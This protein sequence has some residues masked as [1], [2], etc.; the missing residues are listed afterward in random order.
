[1][2]HSAAPG[3]RPRVLVIGLDSADAVLI[4]RW[5]AAGHL[6]VLT[7]L[8]REGVRGR[9]GT[10]AEVMHVSAWPTL[11]TGVDPG[12]HGMYHAYQIRAGEQEIHRAVAS[13]CGA[14]PYWKWLDDAGR[15]CIVLDAFMDYPLAGFRGIQIVDWGTWTW[16]TEAAREASPLVQD[17]R[18][19]VGDYPSPEHSDVVSVPDPVWFRDRLVAGAAAKARAARWLLREHAWD[20]A[21]VT[22]G[23]PHGA[24]HYLWH[25]HDPDFPW[26]RETRPAGLGDPLLEVYAAIDR[27]IGEILEETDDRT[28]VL[29]VS[30]DGM[31]P[32]HS[33][34]HQM[35]AILAAMGLHSAPHLRAPGEA[36]APV[37]ARAKGLLSTVRGAIPLGLRQSI[38]RCLPRRYRHALAMKWANAAIDYGRSQVFLVPNSNEAYLR[39]NLKGREPL[40]MVER[41]AASEEILARVRAEAEG[42]VVPATGRTPT[43]RVWLMDRTFPG[44]RRDDLPDLVVTWDHEARLMGELRAPTAGLVTGAAA[45]Q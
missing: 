23:E 26:P 31:G 45:H 1:M 7:G 5:G 25:W 12:R 10:T 42:L 36:A 40:G 17:L 4:E 8:G 15:R 39:L 43:E 16:F 28:T 38:S 20:M 33:G 18:R 3:R 2:S 37:G 35:P 13:E 32:N 22:F 14:A 11:Y 29:V 44:P 41:G 21:F 9:L 27:A 19:E 24:G 6:P 34:C 30:G